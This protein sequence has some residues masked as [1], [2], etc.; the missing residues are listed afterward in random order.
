VGSA[1]LI[2]G[3][4]VTYAGGGGGGSR[5][6]AGAG[7]TGGGGAGSVG[8]TAPTN[9][10]PNTGGGGGG[11]GNDFGAGQNGNGGTG[12]S[13]IVVI[14]YSDSFDPLTTIGGGLTYSVSTSIRPGFRVYQF[15]A[16]TG[17]VT[18]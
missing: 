5:T 17:S 1:S 18:V 13:G 2:I 12:G 9:G 8:N 15:T 4:S 6:T 14:A 7:G 3:S 11:R 16:G 10:T